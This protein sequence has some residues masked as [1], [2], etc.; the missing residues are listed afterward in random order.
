[1]IFLHYMLGTIFMKNVFHYSTLHL[2]SIYIYADYKHSDS[3]LSYDNL[4]ATSQNVHNYIK[5]IY[6]MLYYINLRVL[7]LNENI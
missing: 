3:F 4:F 5:I 6:N 1:M 7:I 2:L